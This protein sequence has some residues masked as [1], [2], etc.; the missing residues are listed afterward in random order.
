MPRTRI[1]CEMRRKARSLRNHSTRAENLLCYELRDL[2]S[3]ANRDAYLKS[4]GYIILGIDEPDVANSAWRV[5]QLAR[6][7]AINRAGDPTRPLRGHPLLEGEGNVGATA[8]PED[9]SKR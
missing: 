1:S 6:E 2:T 9:G 5:S 4:L 7:R 3:D 8:A